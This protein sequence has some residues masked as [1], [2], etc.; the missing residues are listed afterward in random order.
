[1]TADKGSG[2]RLADRE[3]E[4]ALALE[5]AE[6]GLWDW[7][8]ES[9]SVR[10]DERARALFCLGRDE[11]VNGL[12]ALFRHVH[13]DDVEQVWACDAAA[14]EG[15]R[16]HA[17]LRML[18][19]RGIERWVRIDCTGGTHAP[20]QTG[21]MIGVIGDITFRRQAEQSLRR[22]Q[23]ALEAQVLERTERLTL[24]NAVLANEVEER[25][26]AESRVRELLGQ[27]VSTEEDE[28]RRVS[29]ELH[30]TVGQ[31]LTG[32]T[33]RL[34]LVVNTP[35]LPAEV[36]Q[37]LV[38]LQDSLA[39]LDEDV[40][41]LSQSLSPRTLEDLGLEDALNQLTEDWA[42]ETGVE[43][44]FVARGLADRRWDPV[45]ETTVFRFVQEALT[46]IAR[47]ARAAHATVIVERRY[48]ELRAI[49]EDDG[50]GFDPST[51]PGTGRRGLGLRGMAERAAQAGGRIEIESQPGGGTTLFLA[52]PLSTGSGSTLRL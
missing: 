42:R 9:D 12:A 30:D 45:I 16:F 2:D 5:V 10:A 35:D 51:K 8:L 3:W 41:R 49:V 17:E 23:E 37:H 4:L 19:P 22:D 28:R 21:R 39:R 34:S 48:G 32:L 15:R 31:H 43:L 18:P 14:R 36:R 40:E 6:L 20:G 11:P 1:M 47:H 26:A 7:S 46:N 24:T 33:L 38:S 25:R 52:L 27:I 50:V 29:R 44:Q 13:A